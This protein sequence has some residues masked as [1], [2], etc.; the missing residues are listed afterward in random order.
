[1][2]AKE[3]Q[4]LRKMLMLDAS[5]AAELIGGVS[6]RSWQYWEAGRSPVPADV[7]VTM[8]VLVEQRAKLIDEIEERVKGKP[9]DE[10]IDV[11]ELPFY[12]RFEDYEAANPGKSRLDWRVEQSVSALYFA[13]GMARLA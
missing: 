5:E 2:N 6:P 11:L 10:R 3:L 4:A 13:D 12:Q 9:V 1:M 8:E 7:E